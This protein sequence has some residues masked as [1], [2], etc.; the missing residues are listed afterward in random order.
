MPSSLRLGAAAAKC[1]Q[2]VGSPDRANEVSDEHAEGD[3]PQGIV[4][5]VSTTSR[6]PVS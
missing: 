4:A 3:V 2:R 6:M 5:R 1:D